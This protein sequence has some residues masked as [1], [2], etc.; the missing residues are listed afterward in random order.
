MEKSGYQEAK[1]HLRVCLKS[2]SM[3]GGGNCV[4]VILNGE[5]DSQFADSWDTLHL[6]PF[7][8]M[9]CK[10]KSFTV[11]LYYYCTCFIRY[12]NGSSDAAWMTGVFCISDQVCISKCIM[13]PPKFGQTCYPDEYISIKCGT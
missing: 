7:L 8:Q 3:E 10:Y 6:K 9:H 4:A 13:E 11:Y 5:K 1:L 12:N 2:S